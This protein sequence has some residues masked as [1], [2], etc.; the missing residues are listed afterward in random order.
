MLKKILIPVVFSLVLFLHV[1]KLDEIP[2]GFFVDETSIG[3]NA[4][5]IAKYGFDENKLPYP[6]FFKAF[7]EYKNPLYI[8]VNAV[9]FK[10]LGFSE[11]YLRS[12]SFLFFAIFIIVFYFLI[13][14]I[15]PD[16]YYARVYALI[17]AG[18]LPWFFTVSRI[19]F[20]VISQLTVIAFLLLYI[21]RTYEEDFPSSPYPNSKKL[22]LPTATGFFLGLSVYS[23][24]SSRLLAFLMA[25]TVVLIYRARRYLLRNICFILSFMTSLI[26]YAIFI[27]RHPNALTVRFKETTYLY[28]PALSYL[29]KAL[30]FVKNYISYFT[31][32]YLLIKGD[33]NY[34]M[35][36]GNFG[37]L[38]AAVFGLFIFW[39]YLAVR[40]RHVLE[41]KFVKLILAFL[42]ISPVAGAMTKECPQS[43][44]G[45]LIGLFSLILSAYAFDELKNYKAR[46]LITTTVFITLIAQAS[47][48][49]FVYFFVYPPKTIEAFIGYGFKYA[50]KKGIDYNPKK[51]N[52]VNDEFFTYIRFY[53][54]VLE[55][56]GGYYNPAL[57]N[58]TNGTC[59]LYY[60]KTEKADRTLPEV[61][62]GI[63]YIDDGMTGS[64]FRV[65]C[66]QNSE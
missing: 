25:L 18:T 37:L 5:L 21:Y 8:Y 23:Y 32:Q 10:V 34:R 24:T 64:R 65:R 44:R 11:F 2:M 41:N 28:D 19:S 22:L 7:G 54:Y 31:P 40:K 49:V 46:K 62:K 13:K 61:C 33:T 26:P 1:I 60:D 36:I 63:G 17:S 42:I 9:V 47:L 20:E 3:N 14:R 56:E 16:N 58:K 35:G 53:K 52:L 30:L 6:L 51:L 29:G 38:Y 57:Y 43:L 27:K 39:I 59:Y 55:K 50:F 4:Y 12:T 66:C 45:I 15:F 48:F